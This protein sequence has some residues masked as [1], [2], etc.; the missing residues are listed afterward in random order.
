MN[1]D[2][3]PD[4]QKEMISTETSEKSFQISDINGSFSIFDTENEKMILLQKQIGTQFREDDE[5][6]TI[7]NSV[8]EQPKTLEPGNE[9]GMETNKNIQ[10]GKKISPDYAGKKNFDTQKFATKTLEKER[11]PLKKKMLKKFSCNVCGARDNCM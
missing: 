6:A 4:S 10:Q 3:S 2:S 1:G 5:N 8:D 9:T 11:K 7:R